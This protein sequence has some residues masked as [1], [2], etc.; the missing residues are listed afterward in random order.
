VQLSPLLAA[1]ATAPVGLYEL[2]LNFTVVEALPLLLNVMFALPEVIVVAV[3]S[4]RTC[5]L[6][7][8]VTEL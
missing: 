8:V 2:T 5:R 3:E 1:T 7:V 6:T 4:C